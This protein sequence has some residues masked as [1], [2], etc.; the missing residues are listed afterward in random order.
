M[1]PTTTAQPPQDI[2]PF[3]FQKLEVYIQSREL[4]A[5][6]HRANI[7]DAE[8]RD[9]ATRAAKSVFLNVSEGLPDTQLGVRRRH[10]T[11]ARNSLCEVAAAVD[12]AVASGALPAAVA[13]ELVGRIQRVAALLS[14]LMR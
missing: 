7:G 3:P 12:L 4:A 9:Q 6:V 1:K 11:I 10:F 5:G 14:G 8:L 2:T 13:G